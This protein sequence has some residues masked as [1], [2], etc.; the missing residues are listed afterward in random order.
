MRFED[1]NTYPET[2]NLSV[3][4][5]QYKLIAEFERIEIDLSTRSDY[6]RLKIGQY[7]RVICRYHPSIF[8]RIMEV[9]SGRVILDK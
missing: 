6:H 5:N 4:V 8:R 9:N 1:I 7:A 3:G 2:I